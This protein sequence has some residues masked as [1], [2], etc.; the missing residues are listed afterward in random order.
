M[1]KIAL[2]NLLQEKTR[3]IISVGGVAFSVLLMITLQGLSLGF[4]NVLGQYFT[5]VPTDFWVARANSGNIMDPSFVPL[6]VGPQLKSIDGV[7]GAQPFSM[8][9]LTTS[10][11]GKDS[12]VYLIASDPTNNI[13]VP[14]KVSDGKAAPAQGEI[15]IDRVIAKSNKVK[16][17]NT[18]TFNGRRL[19]VIGFSEGTYLLAGSFGFIN[20]QDAASIYALPGTTNYWL[21]RLKPGTNVS[22]V[23]AAINQIPGVTAHTK[24]HFVKINIDVVR[25]IITPV[26]GALVVLGALIGT[27]VIGLTIFTSTIEKAKEYGI[28]KAIGLKNRQ[29]YVIVLEQ[30]L[31][32]AVIGFVFGAALAYG[33]SPVITSAVPQFITQIRLFDV[34][35]IFVLTMLM[36][37]AASYVPMRRLNKID[38][39]EVFRA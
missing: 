20:K 15:V 16:L 12:Q 8:Q 17:G 28:L 31:I 39:A 5:T 3:L 1:F 34:A 6:S 37:V 2:R 10:I 18:L 33:L 9:S 26:F 32:A 36:A 29:L 4:S 25:S 30:A 27:A 22:T 24:D 35:W 14:T 21:V 7:A 38:P 19:K 13:G 11:N 23:K